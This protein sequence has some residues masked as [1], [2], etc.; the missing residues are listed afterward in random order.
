MSDPWQD[1]EVKR[2]KEHIERDMVPKM[3]SSNVVI[4]IAPPKGKFDVKFAVELGAAI[5]LNKPIIVIS[6]TNDDV[7]PLLRL[8]AHKIVVGSISDPGFQDRLQAVLKG[9]D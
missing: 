8:V 4:S 2:W 1:P 7:P 6:E 9:E 3:E 5:M